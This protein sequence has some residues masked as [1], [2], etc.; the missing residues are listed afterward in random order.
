MG[1]EPRDLWVMSPASYRAAPP[2][3]GVFSVRDANLQS[4]R[5]GRGG[6]GDRAGGGDGHERAPSADGSGTSGAGERFGKPGSTRRHAD[7]RPGAGR[8]QL[9]RGA[10]ADVVHVGA[11]GREGAA[12][13]ERVRVG[14]VAGQ[15]G[16]RHAGGR[17]ADGGKGARE[18][19]GVRVP[20]VVQELPG[21]PGLHQLAGVHHRLLRGAG[22]RRSVQAHDGRRPGLF[23]HD[24]TVLRAG[25]PD[26]GTRKYGRE[27][28]LT[29]SQLT[30]STGEKACAAHSWSW[31][32]VTPGSRLCATGTKSSRN[33]FGYGLGTATSFQAALSKPGQVSPNPLAVLPLTGQ[34][35]R[36]TGPSQWLRMRPPW[37]SLSYD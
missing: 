22:E 37:Q 30:V 8:P 25:G 11:S 32:S 23:A 33:S 35:V 24:S 29:A 13:A 27:L 6:S 5:R 34:S 2:R 28:D 14:R 19:S 10:A 26:Q 18:R 16:R 17:V 4:G 3:V 12:T 36:L 20:G 21:G 31:G 15:P 9:D 7:C 1:C